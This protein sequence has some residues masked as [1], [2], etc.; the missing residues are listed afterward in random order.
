MNKILSYNNFSEE[1]NESFPR[2]YHD[3][4]YGGDVFKIR[5]RQLNNLSNKKGSDLASKPINDLLDQF[6]V[7]DFVTGKAIENGSYYTGKIVGIGKDELGENIDIEI[8]VEGEVRKL[9]PATV[10]M[11]EDIGNKKNG[12][13]PEVDQIDHTSNSDFTPTTYESQN[14]DK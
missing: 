5:Y 11:A 8:E 7:G 4:M 14:T 2:A 13:A 12:T 6:Q 1:V 9:A 10:T 3:P